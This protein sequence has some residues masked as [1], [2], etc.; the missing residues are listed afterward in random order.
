MKL[1]F[2]WGCYNISVN[3]KN[4][5][6]L[7][8]Y[9]L[10]TIQNLQKSHLPLGVLRKK[11]NPSKEVTYSLLSGEKD[12][13]SSLLFSL[14]KPF[15]SKL[16]VCRSGRLSRS[17]CRKERHMRKRFSSTSD[18]LGN[19]CLWVC[20]KKGHNNYTIQLRSWQQLWI[21]RDW[22]AKFWKL[23][24]RTPRDSRC[25]GAA[26]W[27]QHPPTAQSLS[28]CFYMVSLVNL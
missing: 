26:S 9:V 5:P 2:Q 21:S 17:T 22:N 24:S 8:W 10:S 27:P 1:Y 19:K 3:R 11:P 23:D 20:W 14:G 25:W 6:S 4:S 12:L 18:N 15:L 28:L 13:T 16:A 7:A